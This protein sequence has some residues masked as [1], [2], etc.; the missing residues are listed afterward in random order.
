[1][2]LMGPVVGEVVGC[3][4]VVVVGA[5]SSRVCRCVLSCMLSRQ[6]MLVQPTMGWYVAVEVEV[7]SAVLCAGVADAG[8]LVVGSFAR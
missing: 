1:M 6:L 8:V 2:Q 7:V 5:L 3:A 4:Y